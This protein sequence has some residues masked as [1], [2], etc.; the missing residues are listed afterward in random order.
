MA[1]GHIVM[2]FWTAALILMSPSTPWP[3]WPSAGRFPPAGRYR[4]SA[5]G[6]APRLTHKHAHAFIHLQAWKH[7]NILNG[8]E[9][10]RTFLETP[11]EQAGG[12]VNPSG[13]VCCCMF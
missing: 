1:S 8:F 7:N 11:A 5:E 9:Q 12:E 10:D 3:T 6:A 2:L 13:R 4:R